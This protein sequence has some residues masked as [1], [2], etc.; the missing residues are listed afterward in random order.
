M[1]G[2]SPRSTQDEDARAAKRKKLIKRAAIVVIAVILIFA[3]LVTINAESNRA[4]AQE[5]TSTPKCQEA[6]EPYFKLSGRNALTHKDQKP[7]FILDGIFGDGSG[8]VLSDERYIP[9]CD[10]V[11]GIVLTV[12][13]DLMVDVEIIDGSGNIETLVMKVGI[14]G[15]FVPPDPQELLSG[16]QQGQPEPTPTLQT[17]E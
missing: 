7:I 1:S 10:D 5:V 4:S 13:S 16:K 8:S 2:K 3:V 11:G 9:E 14:L 15:G 6:S 12:V 17:H